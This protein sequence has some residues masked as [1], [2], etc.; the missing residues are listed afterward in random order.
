M[1]IT[2]L[3]LP[4][5]FI[6]NFLE[7][8]IIYVI[9]NNIIDFKFKEAIEKISVK[10]ITVGLL[11]ALIISTSWMTLGNGYL[12]ATISI[13]IGLLCMVFIIK[14]NNRINVGI[15]NLIIIF[16]M[17]YLI[18]NI[19]WRLSAIPF[20]FF[21]LNQHMGDLLAFILAFTV[22]LIVCIK[23]DFNNLLIYITRNVLVKLMMFVLALILVIIH[24]TLSSLR[25]NLNGEIEYL[26]LI[27]LLAT[28]CLVGMIF[29]LKNV[30][31][32]TETLPDSIHD[33]KNMLLIL[34]IKTE[35]AT[36]LNQLKLIYN[37]TIDLIGIEMASNILIS[38]DNDFEGFILRTI[39]NFKLQ[40]GSNVEVITNIDYYEDRHGI[41]DV[42]TA[43]MVTSLLENAIETGTKNPI[44]VG[45]FVSVNQMYIQVKNE[46]KLKDEDIEK[47]MKKGYS[48]KG[49]IGR[50]L[51][52]AKLKKLVE[53][54]GG[55][56]TAE[57]DFHETHRVNYLAITIRI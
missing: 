19:F 21:N 42:T 43:Y 57:Q 53:S 27:F 24:A 15:E 26:V 35:E 14:I 8:S 49:S 51:G 31:Y 17:T 1:P 37:Q 7:F 56:I 13:C 2:I 36:S 45:L 6:I 3:E 47:I 28:V 46:S 12:Q 20:I 11:Y 33:I 5:Q 9:V 16:S 48:T 25:Y 34:R 38:T 23:F 10:T 22:T 4:F 44:Y 30:Y 18:G 40:K 41:A 50:G 32:Y 29:A 52:L 55:K 54:E 39:E